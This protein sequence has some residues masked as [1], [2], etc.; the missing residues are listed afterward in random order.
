MKFD[1]ISKHNY[2]HM[3]KKG[4]VTRIV[5]DTTR[6]DALRL[7]TTTTPLG[8][9]RKSILMCILCINRSAQER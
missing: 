5:F 1:K 9:R 6:A 2:R 3:A 7:K 4:E 8:R